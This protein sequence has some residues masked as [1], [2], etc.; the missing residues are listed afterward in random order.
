MKP[1]IE[2]VGVDVSYGTEIV[3]HDITFRVDQPEFVAIV[4]PNGAGK[5]TLLKTSLGII[6]PLKG[7]VTVL[8]ENVM[9][10]PW[11]IRRMVG[12]VPQRERFDYTMPALVKDIVLM[13]RAL[14]RKV[15]EPLRK[16]DYR[17]AEWALRKVGLMD[18]WNEPFSHLSGG[19]Q[20]RVF[21][22]RAL[23][24]EPR[25]LLLDEPFSGVDIESQE[26]IVKVLK[27][28]KSKGVG[29]LVVVHDLNPLLEVVDKILLLN[30]RILAFGKPAE[31]V[32]SSLLSKTFQRPVKVLQAGGVYFILGAD[33][34][35]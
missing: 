31:I 26:I 29:V 15:G 14:R 10:K 4:G 34:H 13:G 12:Y 3:L 5:T 7:T 16:A 6:K 18:L 20:Q 23:V 22:A 9:E 35:A 32:E 27:E 8:G 33:S 30:R 1:L 24:A 25:L 28:Y 19:Q 17:A 2:F 11:K 21:I